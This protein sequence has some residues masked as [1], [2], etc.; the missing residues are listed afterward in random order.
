MSTLPADLARLRE[1][2][3][4]SELET[5]SLTPFAAVHR[6]RTR[7]GEDA[8]LKRTARAAPAMARWLRAL[9]AAGVDVVVPL[10]EA[11]EVDDATWVLY[12][13]I[14]GE[15]YSGT[16]EQ[17]RAAGDLLGRLHAAEVPLEGLRRYAHPSTVRAEV[18][19]DLV[20]LREILHRALPAERAAAA[21]ASITALGARW[22]ERSWPALRAADPDLPRT[23]VSSDWKAANLVFRPE[24]AVLVDPDNGGVEPRLLDLALAL[25]LFP[26]ETPGAPPRMLEPAEWDVLAGAYARHVTL[27]DRERELWPAALDHQW[28]EE[29]TWVL[30]DAGEDGWTD[31][32]QGGYLRSLAEW[33]PALYRLPD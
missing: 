2:F 15:R 6:C 14:E 26:C 16:T 29:G 17:L 11:Q 30:E 31:P 23:G 32:V 21:D 25:V 18:E 4:L 13:Y 27:T 19:A 5:A 7:A 24:G 12:P 1:A 10:V 8:V 9:D 22:F 28:W 3:A 33:D 20:T